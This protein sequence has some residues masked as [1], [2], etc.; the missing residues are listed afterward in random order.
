MIDKFKWYNIFLIY[1]ANTSLKVA[2]DDGSNFTT[3]TNTTVPA[4]FDSLTDG[5]SDSSNPW[6]IGN[7]YTSAGTFDSFLDGRIETVVL[8]DKALSFSE[9]DAIG[10]ETAIP[11]EPNEPVN[12]NDPD[13]I[14]LYV[15]DEQSSG[16][17]E[18]TPDPVFFDTAIT[19]TAQD[20]S[21]FNDFPSDGPAWTSGLPVGNGNG[22]TFD[23]ADNDRTRVEGWLHLT[24]GDYSEGQS[25]TIMARV[26]PTEAVD[27]SQ[28]IIYGL[29]G[30]ETLY[31]EG[32]STGKLQLKALLRD[33]AANGGSETRWWV[34][35][36]IFLDPNKWYNIFLVYNANTSVVLA[37]DDQSSFLSYN[38]TAVP[39]GF[40]SLTHKF[41]DSTRTW[42]IG[43]RSES[44]PSGV[45]A[46]VMD[47]IAVWDRALSPQEAEALN[48]Q[49]TELPYDCASAIAGGYQLTGDLNDDC[50]V[51]FKDL[52]E[53]SELWLI[54]NDPEGQN[55]IWNW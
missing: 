26:K 51:N 28:Y 3:F 27:G 42:V 40:D 15:F 24:Q 45:F 44:T 19:G 14:N 23:K 17:L 10:F 48:L 46:G 34:S 7:S 35:S 20:H 37:A 21:I 12:L 8:W 49:N 30:Y 25:F 4:G 55:C 13:I 18:N 6:V 41:A 50:Y 47:M 1:N 22:L 9:A 2:A 52:Q 29:N 31:M 16:Q 43:S 32:T 38:D 33:G 5:F 54:C 53:L 11:E 39:A 36:D